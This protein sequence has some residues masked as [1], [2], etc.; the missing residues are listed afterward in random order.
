[1]RRDLVKVKAE[2]EATL[3]AG[4]QAAKGMPRPAVGRA[5]ARRRT[6]AAEVTSVGGKL[7]RWPG[8]AMSRR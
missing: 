3:V 2:A 8:K 1:M 6:L 5:L 4:A 7:G